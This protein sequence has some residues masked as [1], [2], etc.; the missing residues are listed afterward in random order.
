MTTDGTPTHS[1]SATPTAPEA[2]RVGPYEVVRRIGRGGMG[3]V[4]LGRREILPGIYHLA[5]V[6]MLRDS[7]SNAERRGL[8]NEVRISVALSHPNLVQLLDVGQDPP[9]VAFE[10]VRGVSL[11]D[12][13]N[14]VEE[15]GP[16]PAWAAASIV[17]E[18]CAGLDA[19]HRATDER[20][21]ALRVVHRDVTPENVLLSWE[22]AVKLAD[23]GVA[24]SS[25]ASHATETGQIK[26]K[27]SY[28][29]P[30]QAN[31][32][33][34]DPRTDVYA[35]GVVLW[36]LL[37]G[38]PLFRGDSH[39]ETLALV[40]RSEVP[41]L[42]EQVH[43][44]DP[45]LAKI[46]HRA[47]H[48]QPGG[49][50]ASAAEMHAALVSAMREAKAHVGAAERA[51]TLTRLLPLR[52]REHEG[53]LRE[54]EERSAPLDKQP[55]VTAATESSART[56]TSKS[57]LRGQLPLGTWASAL[58]TPL[59]LLLLVA[60]ALGV[61]YLSGR[62]VAAP[63]EPSAEIG[64]SSGLNVASESRAVAPGRPSAAPGFSEPSGV[65][66][67]AEDAE[68]VAPSVADS[69]EVV[70]PAGANPRAAPGR[71]AAA[72]RASPE[73][74][75]AT[76]ASRAPEPAPKAPGSAGAPDPFAE[77]GSYETHQ[78]AP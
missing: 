28:L 10:Y 36:E 16:I 70:A 20:G 31:A 60:V 35:V 9:W 61:G 53:W 32:A 45:T 8:I 59:G 18:L 40:L 24:R 21:N 6:K 37:A 62:D 49:R 47:L 69:R 52:V 76:A 68:D 4:Y 34:V 1:T 11:R 74:G 48:A 38:C 5:A 43:D 73:P 54:L 66:L 25:L 26:G 78:E 67:R 3:E 65:R 12:L 55:I 51:M 15:H 33:G 23:L 50:F 42:E 56:G 19:I 2:G 58:R 63:A 64:D 14:A 29:A 13:M 39:G 75:P 30:E 27:V 17:A 57:A 7:L 71:P 46:C 22:G 44:L 41:R 77:R 72:P